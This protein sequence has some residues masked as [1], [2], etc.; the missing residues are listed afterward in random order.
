M[1]TKSIS[2]LNVLKILDESSLKTYYGCNQE[3]YNTE[4][5]RLSGC[6]PCVVS[7][8]IIYLNLPTCGLGQS[9]N[10][11]KD[12]L[13]LMEEIWEYVTPTKEEGIP[14]TKKLYEGVLTYT[15]AKELNVEYAFCDLPKDKFRR[16]QLSEVLF[17]LE[18][19][20]LKDA[21]IAFV[22][23]CNGEEKNLDAWHWVTIV[24]LEYAAAGNR[25][26]ITI[27]D[28]GLIKKIDLGLWYNTTTLGGGFVYFT[29]GK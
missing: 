22:N 17:F 5:Q 28:E 9:I 7:N 10:T 15:K 6:G 25:A 1:I 24:S 18:G 4:W 21:P 16:P 8:I 23:L 13:S 20:L 14:T 3:W 29:H 2:N 19:A 11:K 26:F 12:Y 27:L